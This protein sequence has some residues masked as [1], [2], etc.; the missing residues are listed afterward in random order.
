MNTMVKEYTRQEEL[1]RRG[2]LKGGRI[3]AQVPWDE[4]REGMAV[5]SGWTG[6]V[7]SIRKLHTGVKHRDYDKWIEMD[8]EDNKYSH[9]PYELYD[10]VELIEE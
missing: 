3:V 4:L 5:R 2:K 10:G 6:R 8:F 1:V 9:Q 7:G